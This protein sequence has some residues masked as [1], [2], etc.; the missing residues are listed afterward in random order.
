MEHMFRFI[1]AP[2]ME[3]QSKEYVVAMYR[4]L[5]YDRRELCP[6][7]FIKLYDYLKT[8]LNWPTK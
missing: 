2:S 8:G 7:F 3:M 1:I 5:L 6:F 4:H